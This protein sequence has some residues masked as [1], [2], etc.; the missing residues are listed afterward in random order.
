MS[1]NQKV[2]QEVESFLQQ[3]Q[4]QEQPMRGKF[5][6]FVNEVASFDGV[7]LSFVARPGV[8]YS[9]RPR[10]RNQTDR[11]LF[12]IIDVIDDDPG[13]RW[14]SVCFYGDMISDPEQRGE[15]IPGGLGG[16][17]GYCFDMFEDDGEYGDY[18]VARFKEA[19]AAAAQ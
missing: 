16:E 5:E 10:H 18:L 4:P 13:E 11:E 17:D 9:V 14:L 19:V 7:T 15:V 1:E 8:S 12:A 6:L 2:L 3:W